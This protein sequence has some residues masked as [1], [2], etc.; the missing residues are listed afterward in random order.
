MI[1]LYVKIILLVKCSWSNS[2]IVQCVK[3]YHSLH[4]EIYVNKNNTMLY[5]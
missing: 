2:V 1:L 3:R 5:C 4:Y